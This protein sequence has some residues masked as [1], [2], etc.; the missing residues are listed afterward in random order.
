M[1]KS[2]IVVTVEGK[3]L[4]KR[5]TKNIRSRHCDKTS[6]CAE[7][8]GGARSSETAP[9]STSMAGVALFHGKCR[10]WTVLPVPECSRVGARE[11]RAR[12]PFP[13]LPDRADVGTHRGLCH[14]H[15]LPTALVFAKSTFIFRVPAGC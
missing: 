1:N 12:D 2:I 5:F 10:S 3:I 13:P 4:G 8:R 9:V 6:I 15:F 7:A 14:F 11:F